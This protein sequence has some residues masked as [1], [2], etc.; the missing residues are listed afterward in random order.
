LSKF[1]GDPA[2]AWRTGDTDVID[3]LA[4]RQ[5]ASVGVKA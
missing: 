4:R 3:E 5:L 2:V 1:G